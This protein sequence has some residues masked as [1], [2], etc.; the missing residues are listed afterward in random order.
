MAESLSS[1]SARARSQKQQK[2]RGDVPRRT[3]DAG[4]VARS[5]HFCGAY[6]LF[7]LK[8]RSSKDTP[9]SDIMT[10]ELLTDSSLSSHSTLC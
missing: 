7:T 10:K 4:G 6:Q 2:K 9:V 5:Y 8:G 1:D 3:T